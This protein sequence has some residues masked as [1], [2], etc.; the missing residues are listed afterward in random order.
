SDDPVR[1]LF[2]GDLTIPYLGLIYHCYFLYEKV[3]LQRTF[4]QPSRSDFVQITLFLISLSLLS[5]T[6]FSA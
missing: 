3:E 5:N 1:L 4:S 6:S 2:Y